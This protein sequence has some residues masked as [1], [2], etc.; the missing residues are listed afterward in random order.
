MQISD[1][2]M[3]AVQDSDEIEGFGVFDPEICEQRQIK[4]K[5]Q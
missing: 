5:I 1:G 4:Y 3:G 2:H